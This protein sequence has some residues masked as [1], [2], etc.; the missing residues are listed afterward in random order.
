MY[1]LRIVVFSILAV[2]AMV[3]GSALS[4]LPARAASA[5]V[6]S[7]T[8]GTNVGSL[9]TSRLL[10]ASQGGYQATKNLH[11]LPAN[12]GL[13][14]SLGLHQI[15]IDHIF[16]DAFYSAVSRNSTGGL[17]LDFS[18]LDSV[19]LPLFS[20][21]MS[22]WFTL[23]YTPSALGSNWNSAPNSVS[24]WS[25]V[26]SAT[27]A[28][29]SALGH[30]G[31]N[32]EFWNEP[33]GSFW[34]SGI[35]A[36]ETFYAATAHA[37]KSS[38]PT[39]QVGGPAV[40]NINSTLMS[41]FLDYIA[42]NPT[43]PLDFVSWH[44]YGGTDFSSASTVA[45]MLSSRGIS[46][47]KEYITEW[48]YTPTSGSSPGGGAD[49]NDL[50]SYSARRLTS[51]LAQP[52]LTGVFIFSP[53]EGWTPTAD[54]S[55]DLGLTTIDGHR[56]AGANV[57]DML[58]LM[59]NTL[60]SSAIS[61]APSDRSVGAIATGDTTTQ[62]LA[63]LAWNDG[64]DA[65]SFQL[66]ASSLPFAGS[67]F[68]VMR[69]DVN[70]VAG[71]YYS[72]WLSGPRNLSPGTNEI[73]RPSSVSVLAPATSW[74]TSTN[75]SAKS[76]ALFVLVPTKDATGS[77][78]L[79]SPPTMANIARGAS[80]TT[81]SSYVDSGWSPANLVDGRRHTFAGADSGSP[82]NGFT[83]A[84]D[85]TAGSTEWAKL[86]L[87]A[88]KQ[89][90]TV[91]LWPR[92]D[93][94]ADGSSFPVDF[95]IAGSNDGSAWSTLAS[96]VGYHA[97]APVFGPQ[98]F[99]VAQSSF[100]YVR[101]TATR[102]GQPVTELSGIVY[103]LQLAELEIT[104]AGLPNPSFETG[105]LSAW[106]A[107][108][109]ATVV[110]DNGY[111]GQYAATFTG[112]GQ[113]IF[114]TINGLSPNTTYEFGGFLRSSVAGDPVYIGVKNYGGA[115]ISV[116]ISGTVYKQGWVRFTTSSTS[117]SAL[118]YVYKN[119]GSAQSWVDDAMLIRQ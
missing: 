76:V 27:V 17:V 100:R 52:A 10:N 87:G 78:V 63:I 55:T 12:Y 40:Y 84:A 13:I 83:S 61:G 106:S 44:D 91:T 104:N 15:R 25:S 24:E 49:T 3:A 80:V 69:Y 110:S 115:E 88:S 30:S 36:Y 59:P 57:F 22:P 79:S 111:D 16:D 1:R 64:A 75:L 6:V 92:D 38:D 96:R 58:N 103:R 101:L 70:G 65:S 11:Y 67:N 73:L 60:L 62:S 102:L 47:R 54:F 93:Q 23:S 7:S 45:T 34:Q 37:V 26:V 28:H 90:D 86:D 35:S 32:W 41:S 97:G 8:Y 20:E 77:A 39:A 105:D 43:V 107:Y 48:N 51:A 98:V 4:A 94:A 109:A 89:F 18:R 116:P 19:V 56:K 74:S 29:Y 113:G 112:T 50:V 81:S 71:N 2:L 118:V 42:A 114:Q 85:L 46:P 14:S 108:G 82:T 72:D 119:S 68:K 53:L 95:V 33:D 66:N 5:L 9:G 99:S 21:G 31:L 117:T